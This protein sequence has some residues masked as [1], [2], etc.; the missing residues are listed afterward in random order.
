MAFERLDVKTKQWLKKQGY[1]EGSL[2]QKLAIPDILEGKDVLI[3]APTGHGKTLAAVLPIFSKLAENPEKPGIRMLYISP[4]K[5]LNRDI[6]DRI[7]N[8]ATHLELSVDL[9]HGDTPPKIR[10]QQLRDPADVLI[11]TP[12]AI[13]SILTGKKFRELLRNVEYVVID[14][15]H[16]ICENKRGSQLS[17]ALERLQRIIPKRFQRIGLSA[18][19][20]DPDKI[21]KFLTGGSDCKIIDART[22]KKYEIAVEYPKPKTEDI[23]AAKRLRVTVTGAY[24]IRR[25][26]ELIDTSKSAI[27]FVNTR[28]TAES[29]GAR[30]RVFEPKFPIAVHHSSLSK[31]VR[32]DVENKFK[33]GELKAIISTS[34]LELGIDIGDIDLVI[35]YGSPRQV[36]KIVQRVGR[37]GHRVGRTS[38]GVI[39]CNS[40]DDYLEA[41]AIIQKQNEG[42][43]EHPIIPDK[44]FDVL[45]H[46]I[47]GICMDFSL[48]EQK[49]TREIMLQLLKKSYSFRNL[50]ADE[51][52]DVISVMKDVYLMQEKEG[53]LFRTKK[54]LLYYFENLSTIPNEKSY[55]VIS[56]ELNKKI[57][58]LHQGFVAQYIKNGVEFVMKGEPWRVVEYDNEKIKVVGS[59]NRESAIPSW[60]GELIPVPKQI[61]SLASDLR[62]KYDFDD[63][64]RQKSDFVVPTSKVMYIESYEDY[65]I[66][67]S[68]FGN[69][70]NNTLSKVIG[71]LISSKVGTSV[72]ARNDT[73]R[74]IFKIPEFG[75]EL[76]TQCLNELD[77][78]WIESILL[79]SLRNTSMFEFRF[80]QIAKRFGIISK[81][82]QFS[83]ST[84]SKVIDIYLPT[85][86]YVET[87]NELFREKLDIEGAKE[88]INDIK[89]G[90]I[91]IM[92]SAG[93]EISPLG[94]EGLDYTSISFITPKEK[95]K[96]I[97]ELIDQ[98]LKNR[99]L[100][101]ACLNCNAQIGG[102]KVEKIPDSMTCP[103]CKAKLIGFIPARDKELA[104]KV[105][106]K[107]FAKE[108]LEPDELDL[109]KKFS[110]SAE[111]FINYGKKACYVLA[112]YGI[113]PRTARRILARIHKTDDDL[114]RDIVEAE[115]QFAST[116]PFWK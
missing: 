105:L 30:F 65:S 7:V 108:E 39:I 24:C 1:L 26:K 73:Y 20:G 10:A 51:L 47:I 89:S 114:L 52:D 42:W 8:L 102:Y 61:A 19:I 57:G 94:I 103:S 80:Y 44:P 38:K 15:I 93:Y 49:L 85:P 96:E 84:L 59:K 33:S 67:H 64:K 27:V 45:S 74:M 12:E 109:F 21:S 2:P 106:N 31:D 5:S 115:R 86:V 43:L 32:I 97:Y 72:G 81:D 46:Q 18:T 55:E 98:R 29:L 111:L 11:I 66:I 99:D 113:G 35:Q 95:L 28:E 82:A 14:E 107:H 37:S 54:G 9:R 104:K 63:L 78:E 41:T 79:R 69:K 17:I 101:F 92:T 71:A 36:T 34:S 25:I 56:T 87:I 76:I 6:F 40:V 110:E 90:K 77:P 53:H 68:C 13:Q 112:G 23:E 3:I 58:V 70:I 60:E 22:E 16:E 48:D 83:R 62:E 50:T 116:R 100:W 91:K 75:Q 88:V 4:L